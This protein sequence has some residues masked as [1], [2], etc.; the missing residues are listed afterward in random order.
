M[1]LQDRSQVEALAKI[2]GRNALITS[3]YFNI[4]K[5]RQ[6]KKEIGVSLKHLLT[7]SREKLEAMPL[8]KDTKDSLLKDLE[9]IGTYATEQITAARYP[10]I[11]V[12]AAGGDGLWQDFSL[13]DP[14]HNRVIF[15]KTPYVKPLSAILEEHRYICVLLTD[16]REA[17][18][19]E[20]AMGEGRLLDT[21]K[22]DVPPRVKPAGFLGTLEKNI[23]RHVNAHVH[24]HFKK[25]A[26]ITFDLFKKRPFDWLFIGTGEEH[27]A[28]LEDILH[29]YLR[30]RL[31]AWLKARPSSSAD[32]VIKEAIEVQKS[33]KKKEEEAL[34][35]RLV[36]ELEKNGRAVS[37]IKETLASLNSYKVMSLV[38]TRDYA[39]PGYVC[40]ACGRISLESAP[41]PSC[42]PKLE[43]V[44]D[45]V[46]EAVEA[47]LAK[48]IPVRYVSSPSRLD[49]FGKIGAFLTYKNVP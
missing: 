6:I 3:F 10:G 48:G 22:S 45:V 11:A 49:R 13:P 35:D 16:R 7:T 47:A 37:G 20:I 14:P 12:F 36:T 17:Q 8:D 21:L 1:K 19:Y 28:G 27:H 34:V 4:D 29:P 23:D 15:E 2:K 41:C 18:W 43:P 31:K 9:R 38:V 39:A 5:A 24:E 42:P 44:S 40:H 46:D 30:E 33:V 25:A 26:Q 32:Q